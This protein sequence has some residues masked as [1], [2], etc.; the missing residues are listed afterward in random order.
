MEMDIKQISDGV[1]YW[2][3]I[4]HG[5]KNNALNHPDLHWKLVEMW[6]EMC[7]NRNDAEKLKTLYIKLNTFGKTIEKKINDLSLEEVDGVRLFRR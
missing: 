6:K 1:D 4:F 7:N 5:L 3:K 2:Y